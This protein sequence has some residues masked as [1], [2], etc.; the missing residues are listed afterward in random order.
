M[1]C[2]EGWLESR[3][4]ERWGWRVLALRRVS[5]TLGVGTAMDHGTELRSRMYEGFLS[6]REI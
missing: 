4:T 6:S 1:C 3:I 5:S 2:L